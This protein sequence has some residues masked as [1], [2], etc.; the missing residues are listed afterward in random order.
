MLDCVSRSRERITILRGNHETRQVTQIYGFYDECLKK[1][2]SSTVWSHL[3]DIFDFLPLTAVV[4]GSVFCLHG[5]LSPSV[6]SLDHIRALDRLQEAPHEGP[7]SDLL[8]SDP[9]EDRE[10]WGIS[11]RG[12]GHTFGPDISE[13]FNL[14]NGLSLISRA[15]QMPMEGYS[16]THGHHLVTIFS[17]PNYC[18]RSETKM[19][20]Y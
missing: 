1:Y 13:A 6:S 5:G 9:E 19:M 20:I 14:T 4:A 10:G 16:W 11:P 12:A 18:Y 8:W 2:G 7:M 15:H 17:A 3:T